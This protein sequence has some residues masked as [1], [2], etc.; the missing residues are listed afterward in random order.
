MIVF[1]DKK[2]FLYAK[3]MINADI[4]MFHFTTMMSFCYGL[5]LY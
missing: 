3:K 2:I 5:L 1:D 4:Y